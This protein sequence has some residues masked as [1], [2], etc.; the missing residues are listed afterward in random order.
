METVKLLPIALN[1]QDKRCL[2]VGGG[3]VAARK[4]QSLVEC[5]ARVVVIA[6]AVGATFSTTEPRIIHVPRPYAAG[7]GAG[8][9]LI[10]AC[11]DDKEVNA[12]VAREAAE[13]GV[14][15]NVADDAAASDF[16]A[17]AA[18]RR[19]DICIGITTSGGSPALARHLKAR[20]E[21]S[22]GAEFEQLL[23]VMSAR[24][25]AVKRDGGQQDNRAAAWNA[26][27]ESDVLE[28]LKAGE[29]ERAEA[30][31]DELLQLRNR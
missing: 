27:L 20:V 13:R 24:R 31:V 6:P 17:A 14:L 30:L 18:V 2:V 7:D 21:E 22:V 26:V 15:C 8:F 16:H 23:D 3:T 19:G 11:T 10:F 5:G 28:L 12:A 4:A 1:V 29:R 25:A 9:A